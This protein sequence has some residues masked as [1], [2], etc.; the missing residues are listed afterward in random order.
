L[1][2]DVQNI[3]PCSAVTSL[4]A[5]TILWFKQISRKF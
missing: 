4:V 5:A 3:I 1:A 2:P